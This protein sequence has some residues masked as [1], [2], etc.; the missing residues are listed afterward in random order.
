MLIK[1][2]CYVHTVNPITGQPC[3]IRVVVTEEDVTLWQVDQR[4]NS[5]EEFDQID[6]EDMSM[7]CMPREAF[8]EVVWAYQEICDKEAV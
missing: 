6:V 8:R 3:T 4:V 7:I 5:E 2:V 1:Q